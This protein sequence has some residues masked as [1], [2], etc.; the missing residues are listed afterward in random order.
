MELNNLKVVVIMINRHDQSDNALNAYTLVPY[1]SKTEIHAN[2]QA[3]Q[4]ALTCTSA[5]KPSAGGISRF[6]DGGNGL[7]PL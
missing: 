6:L 4:V 2:K 3:L 5:G 1:F 7:H